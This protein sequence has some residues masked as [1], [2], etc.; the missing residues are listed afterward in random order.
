M[1][2]LPHIGRLHSERNEYRLARDYPMVAA[3]Y[4]AQRSALAKSSGLSRKTAARGTRK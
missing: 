2:Q 3:N 1:G 4:A